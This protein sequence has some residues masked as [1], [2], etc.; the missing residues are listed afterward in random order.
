MD[1]KTELNSFLNNNFKSVPFKFY[2]QK[3]TAELRAIFSDESSAIL[4][5][6]G[7]FSK[8]ITRE[9]EQSGN[10]GKSYQNARSKA[11][12][13]WSRPAV[14]ATVNQCSRCDGT[15]QMPFKHIAGGA[16]FRCGGTGRK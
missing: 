14:K 5:W 15:G 12:R 6:I 16:C 13:E 4:A 2:Y 8:H 9:V 10:C 3:S 7:L 1:K 11:Y